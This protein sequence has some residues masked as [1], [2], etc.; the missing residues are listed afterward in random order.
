MA[1]TYSLNDMGVTADDLIMLDT[2]GISFDE[3][4]NI[5][6]EKRD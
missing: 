2:A 1:K 3:T 6:E 4:D 5:S